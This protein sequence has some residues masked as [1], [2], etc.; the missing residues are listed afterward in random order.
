VPGRRLLLL[1]GGCLVA[2]VAV[3]VM[4]L[5]GSGIVALDHRVADALGATYDGFYRFGNRLTEVVSPAVDTTVLAVTGA[6]L[7]LRR[8]RWEPVLTAVAA[9]ALCA[10]VVLSV[11]VG[12][13]RLAPNGYPAGDG[14][15][16]PSGHTAAALVLLGTTALLLTAGRSRRWALGG[17]GVLTALVGTALVYDRFHWLSDVVGSLLIGPVLLWAVSRMPFFFS[18]DAER[19]PADVPPAPTDRPSLAG[20]RD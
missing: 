15:D 12:V 19:T 14:G 16:F 13:G 10:A 20:L 8:H 18:Y 5:T 2:F 3:T 9:I 17:V 11:K 4:V 6:V 1:L 7:S